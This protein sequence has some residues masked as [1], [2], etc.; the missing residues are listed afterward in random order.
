MANAK[1]TQG[2]GARGALPGGGG[3]G[4]DAGEDAVCARWGAAPGQIPGAWA[5]PPSRGSAPLFSHTHLLS[6]GSAGH[7]ALTCPKSPGPSCSSA[8]EPTSPSPWLR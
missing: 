2:E 5:S 1:Y 7:R 6:Q 8:S 4:G 3:Q